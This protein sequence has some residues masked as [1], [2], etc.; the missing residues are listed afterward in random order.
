MKLATIKKGE[1]TALVRVT[2]EGYVE[3][4]GYASVSELLEA[5]ALEEARTAEGESGDLASATLVNPL[6]NPSKIICVGVNY[7]N[8]IKEMGREPAPYP[9]LFMKVRESLIGPNDPIMLPPE[10]Q[11]VDYEG[12]LAMVIGTKVRRAKGEQARAAIA[13][14]TCSNDTSM[15]DWQY[16]TAQ[17]DQG[18]AWER[19]TPIGPVV[20]T[21]DELPLDA[22]LVTEVNGEVRQDTPV[23]DLV[24]G[25][26]ELVE[27]LSTIFTLN[28]GDVI[29]TGTPGGV[30]HAKKPP[31]YVQA[32]DIVSVTIDG[33]GTI[34]N[35]AEAE[36]V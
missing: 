11:A 8:H 10:S 18:K 34:K 4:P 28:P 17:W 16:R 36:E 3:V 31:Q 20:V 19:A 23:D 2:G 21:P 13:G 30:G 35:R 7:R 25:T 27:Y 14:F 5:G 32:G 22:R 15:R 33:I 24:F 12:E 9:T 6:P 26:V 1:V 29:L